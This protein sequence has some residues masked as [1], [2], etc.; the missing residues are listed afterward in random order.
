MLFILTL[1]FLYFL[2]RAIY[3]L[4]FSG[5]S[6]RTSQQDYTRRGYGSQGYSNN[7]DI[8]ED[9]LLKVM[10]AAMQA[11][12]RVTRD[13]LSVVKRVLVVQFGEVRA[14]SAL[15]RLRDILKTN[16]DIRQA[17]SRIG[18]M[19]SYSDRLRIAD[20]LCKIAEAD[21]IITDSEVQTIVNMS[22]YMGISHVDTQRIASHLHVN[23][24]ERGNSHSYYGDN[25][26]GSERHNGVAA[27][28]QTL[29]VNPD[30]TNEEVKTAYRSL[31]KK[32]HPDRYA[33]QSEQAQKA[34]A[35]KFKQIQDA[36]EKI[37][38]ARGV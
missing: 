11:D 36:Y 1:V 35:E 33:T 2:V 22:Y 4:F 23:G 34:A 38:A 14:Q 17:A 31:V 9:A 25:G 19:L 27:A 37:K 16:F 5:E 7:D 20:I 18:S 6:Q 28:Y 21:G 26:Y 30:A 12:G 29:G 8:F 24:G 32:Y 13:E 15:L 3:N 10:A